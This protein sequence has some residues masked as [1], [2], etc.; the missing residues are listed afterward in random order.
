[1]QRMI[2]YYTGANK[3]QILI[4]YKHFKTD[5]MNAIDAIKES[6]LKNLSKELGYTQPTK[7]IE[8]IVA[9]TIA[10]VKSDILNN[11]IQQLNLN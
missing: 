11:Q 10:N 1:M 3:V 4:L 8:A 9:N 7:L 2:V 5:I 6:L